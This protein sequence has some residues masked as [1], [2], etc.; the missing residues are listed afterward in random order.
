MYRFKFL[1]VRPAAFP[2]SGDG[3][4]AGRPAAD[5]QIAAVAIQ[6]EPILVTRN[7]KDF[8]NFEIQVFDPW[9]HHENFDRAVNRL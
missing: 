3:D 9:R 4:R 6:H 1:S 8:V 2:S 7:A 5:A